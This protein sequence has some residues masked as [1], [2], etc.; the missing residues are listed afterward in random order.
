MDLITKT[1]TRDPVLAALLAE[2]G[3]PAACGALADVVADECGCCALDRNARSGWRIG[4]RAGDDDALPGPDDD[5]EE[6]EDEGGTGGTE[7]RAP[8]A[9]AR[10]R[11]HRP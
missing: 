1:R 9:H 2:L 4:W 5:E 3:P 11:T 10:C 6:D 8:A 7:D